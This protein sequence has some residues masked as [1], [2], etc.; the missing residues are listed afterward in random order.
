[1]NSERK[2]TTLEA[3]PINFDSN[4]LAASRPSFRSV[5]CGSF[6]SFLYCY[7]PGYLRTSSVFIASVW[8]LLYIIIRDICSLLIHQKYNTSLS[9]K[10][11]YCYESRCLWTFFS[12]R[13]VLFF[14]ERFVLLWTWLPL[15]LLC[16]YSLGLKPSIL[17]WAFIVRDICCLLIHQKYTTPRTSTG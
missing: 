16:F 12:E 5:L 4:N 11:S 13:S 6:W 10:P 7:G 3:L 17:L 15:D 14:L 2:Q 1:M 9:F 8:N